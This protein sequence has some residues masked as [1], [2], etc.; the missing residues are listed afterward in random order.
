MNDIQ[1]LNEIQKFCPL[2]G[3]WNPVKRLGEGSFGAVWEMDREEENGTKKYSAVKHISLP[4]NENEYQD[5]QLNGYYKD[6]QSA[7]RYYQDKLDSL[8]NEIDIMD[9]LKGNTNIVT[10]MNHVII[11]KEDMPGFDIFILMELLTPLLKHTQNGIDKD[12]HFQKFL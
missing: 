4:K 10:Y 1:K 8:M 9:E 3:V 12:L 6:E 2:D 11:K 5:K 7:R